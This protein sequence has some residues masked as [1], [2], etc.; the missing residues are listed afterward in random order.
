MADLKMGDSPV[1]Q[2]SYDVVGKENIKSAEPAIDDIDA[3]KKPIVEEAKTITAADDR[4]SAAAALKAQEQDEL[5]LQE[6]PHRFVL[7]PIKYHEAS[8]PAHSKW[9]HQHA[10]SVP[11]HRYGRCTRRQRRASG[12]PRRLT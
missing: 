3:V 10:N 11:R 8:L 9:F 4:S 12:R 7:F 6:N 2:L 1:K 5:I